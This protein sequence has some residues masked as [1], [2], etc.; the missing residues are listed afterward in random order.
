MVMVIEEDDDD[1]DDD[2]GD[3]AAAACDDD[4]VGDDGHG[5]TDTN[6]KAG[7]RR[8]KYCLRLNSRVVEM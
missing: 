6:F 5:G 1:D 7:Q 2:N 8:T 3:V 4:G